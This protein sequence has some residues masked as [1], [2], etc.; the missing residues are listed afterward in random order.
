[1]QICRGFS[2]VIYCTSQ[3]LTIKSGA[4]FIDRLLLPFYI[5]IMMCINNYD[6]DIKAVVTIWVGYAT[7]IQFQDGIANILDLVIACKARCLLIDLENM[8]LIGAKDQQWM[9]KIIIPSLVNLGVGTVAIIP[10]SNYFNKV[11]VDT[12]AASANVGNL[13]TVFFNN[14]QEGRRFLKHSNTI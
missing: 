8:V 11:A 4:D 3:E 2:N 13:K 9:S 1:L 14:L 5:S 12:I 10:P 6:R 7:S